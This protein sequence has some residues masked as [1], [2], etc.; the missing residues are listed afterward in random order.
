[1]IFNRISIHRMFCAVLLISAFIA[2][3]SFSHFVDAGTSKLS[4]VSH[5]EPFNGESEDGQSNS[6]SNK[7]EYKEILSESTWQATAQLTSPNFLVHV[8]SLWSSLSLTVLI[9]P[10][11]L[12]LIIS[13]IN[14]F[15]F[16]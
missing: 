9:Q 13:R 12:G 10:P 16:H 7:I 14:K 3:V 8:R 2:K 5:S 15:F 4:A 6:L 11:K 1:M